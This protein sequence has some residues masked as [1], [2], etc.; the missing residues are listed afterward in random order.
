MR[1]GRLLWILG[2]GGLFAGPLAG[3]DFDFEI[4]E[5]PE[6]RLEVHGNLDGKWGLLQTRKGSPFYG[7]RF[8]DAPGTGDYLSQYRLEF[9]LNGDYRLK[10]VGFFARTFAQSVREEPIQI[11]FFELYGSL[12]LSPRF[13]VGLGKRRYSW[14]KG[15]AFNPAG[16]VNAEKD[17]ENPD[18]ALSGRA[19]A[20][21]VYN[22]SFPSGWV[23]NVSLTGVVLPPAPDLLDRYASVSYTGGALKLY[24]LVRDTDIDLMAFR[25]KGEPQKYGLDLSTNLKSNLEIHG[26]F[27]YVRD[28]KKYVLQG[29]RLILREVNGASYLLGTRYLAGSTN[30]TIIAEYYHHPPGLSRDEFRD[31]VDFLKRRLGSEDSELMQE[32]GA[33][34]STV[35]RSRTAMQ[36]YLYMKVTQPEPFGWVY[37]SVSA[38]AIYN[39]KDRS[40]TLSP[41]LAY[42]PY[43]NFEF[44]LWPTLFSGGG[45]T[46]FG[47]RQ[48]Q[49]KVEIW[50]RFHF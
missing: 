8:H 4:P 48:F 10:Q 45:Q 29:D 36:D 16:H 9:Y 18:L 39:V 33:A 40:F 1:P 7:L 15:Y 38:F 19:S 3:E 17:P 43:T 14:G 46:E 21:F 32:A 47:S 41:Q 30:T 49:G 34:L 35:F 25:Q 42:K 50:T 11:S 6:S 44:L 23:Q 20:Y 28:A 13:T 22:R 5:E 24:V 2:I 26:E 12:N 31:A 37:A 27:S